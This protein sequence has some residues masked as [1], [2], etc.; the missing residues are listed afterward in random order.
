MK[1][2]L[3]Y[4]GIV[5]LLFCGV[6]YWGFYMSEHWMHIIDWGM[7][8]SWFGALL[9]VS[10]LV[11][12]LPLRKGSKALAKSFIGPGITMPAFAL[13]VLFCAIKFDP[14]W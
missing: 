1:R 8:W 3:L 4:N 7:P 11:S 9:A 10:Y 2:L 13:W 5:L 14:F 6:W 12:L